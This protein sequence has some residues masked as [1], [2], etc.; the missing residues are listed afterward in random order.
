MKY[1][2]ISKKYWTVWLCTNHGRQTMRWN[3]PPPLSSQTPFP[4]RKMKENRTKQTGKE[5]SL[6]LDIQFI[7]WPYVAYV[8][9]A[10]HRINSFK[11]AADVLTVDVMFSFKHWMTL[12]VEHTSNWRER[13]QK[14]KPR[15]RIQKSEMS[16][17]ITY[18]TI[19]YSMYS[20]R[21]SLFVEKTLR[22][23]I[24]IHCN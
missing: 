1:M 17:E 19:Y 15:Q 22:F 5:A 14:K 2:S 3:P 11:H 8:D 7:M 12:K 16:F 9:S 20:I 24:V 21:F 10:Q 23:Y 18:I 13:C 4:L 6:R